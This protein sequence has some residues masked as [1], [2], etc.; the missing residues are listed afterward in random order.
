MVIW[1]RPDGNPGAMG[2][3]GRGGHLRL[4]GS[5]IFLEKG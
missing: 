2:K 1:G 3:V 4:L 5:W